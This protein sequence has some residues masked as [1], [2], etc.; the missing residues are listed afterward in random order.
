MARLS[1]FVVCYDIANGRRRRKVAA[2]LDSYGDRVQESVF[3]VLVDNWRFDNCMA[4][5]AA[6]IDMQEDNVVVYRLCGSCNR[7]RSYYGLGRNTA[8]IGEEE[9]FIV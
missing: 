5:L 3:E 8:N 4:D 2:C 1:R 7:E 6:L 9:V